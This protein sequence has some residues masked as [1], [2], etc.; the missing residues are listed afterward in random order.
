M[1]EYVFNQVCAQYYIRQC[2]DINLHPQATYMD[3]IVL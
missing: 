2:I 3:C 1:K